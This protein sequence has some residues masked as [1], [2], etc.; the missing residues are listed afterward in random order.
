MEEVGQLLLR[1]RRV[2]R[3]HT[4]NGEV[5]TVTYNK[6][7][8]L[9]ESIKVYNLEVEDLHTYYVTN[10]SVLVHNEYGA[11]KKVGSYV[12]EFENGKFYIG[13]GPKS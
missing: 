12:I 11:D 6:E 1:L 5:V 7:E 4:A 3:L 9:S 13:K 10:D 8:W 2:T